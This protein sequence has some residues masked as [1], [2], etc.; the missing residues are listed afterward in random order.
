[1]IGLGNGAMDVVMNA[2]GVQVG[3]ARQRP[4]MSFF[5]A[6]WSIGNFIGAGAILLPCLGCGAPISDA[7]SHLDSGV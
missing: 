2:I 1:V 3:A 4:I 7:R 5:H 6:L